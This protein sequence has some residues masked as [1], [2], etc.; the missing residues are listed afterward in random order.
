MIDM[1]YALIKQTIH[2][3]RYG[4]LTPL[5]EIFVAYSETTSTDS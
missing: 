1:D 4:T 5:Y 3:L 2:M